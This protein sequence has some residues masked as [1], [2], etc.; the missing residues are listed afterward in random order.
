MNVLI[1]EK[2]NFNKGEFHKLSSS[3]T[4]TGKKI[5]PQVSVYI[6]NKKISTDSYS[7]SFKNNKKIG[8]ATITAKGK[9]KYAGKKFSETFKIVPKFNSKITVKKVKGKKHTYIISWK[10]YKGVGKVV[11][12]YAKEYD[13][14]FNPNYNSE[15]SYESTKQNKYASEFDEDKYLVKI[16][17]KVGY[18]GK[19]YYTKYIAKSFK[20][21]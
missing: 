20:A 12:Y 1:G 15:I 8:T 14:S 19:I 3:Y 7:L 18:K 16:R 13:T 11:K 10:E 9:G 4:Y 5:K 2:N 6:G 21:S 17:A